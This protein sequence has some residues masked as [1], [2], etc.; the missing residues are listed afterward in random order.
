MHKCFFENSQATVDLVSNSKLYDFAHHV[1][2]D[3][4]GN[5]GNSLVAHLIHNNAFII[6]PGGRGQAPSWHTDDP[7]QPIIS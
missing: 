1:I 3:I 5:R 6:P 4:P 7:L 2:S